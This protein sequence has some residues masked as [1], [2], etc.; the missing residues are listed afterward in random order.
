MLKI[1]KFKKDFNNF[2][3]KKIK[4]IYKNNKFIYQD[5]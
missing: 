2:Y 5:K 4:K 3:K 1:S